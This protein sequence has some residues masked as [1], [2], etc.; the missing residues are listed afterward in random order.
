MESSTDL[1]PACAS[2]RVLSD[3]DLNA[4]IQSLNVKQRQIFDIIYS[5]GKTFVQNRNTKAPFE[6]EPIRIFLTAPGGCGKSFF[7]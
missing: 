5:W 4:K 2:I 1:P 7:D 3:D 6:L